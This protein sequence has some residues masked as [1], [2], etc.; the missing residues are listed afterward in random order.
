MIVSSDE[1]STD[2]LGQGTHD[3]LHLLLPAKKAKRDWRIE[4]RSGEINQE[5]KL[6][7]PAIFRLNKLIPNVCAAQ[8]ERT[9]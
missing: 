7:C 8:N 3:T 9:M 1:L 4:K 6:T 2:R 5:G